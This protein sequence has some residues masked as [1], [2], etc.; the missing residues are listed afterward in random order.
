MFDI[1]ERIRNIELRSKIVNPEVAIRVFRKGMKVGI[2]GDI[3]PISEALVKCVEKS[4]DVLDLTLWSGVVGIDADLEWGRA[5]IIAR[6]LGQQTLLKEFINQGKVS[7]SDIPLG[8][9]FYQS[10][11][12]NQLGDLDVAI[13]EAISITKEGNIIPG[14]TL[15]DMPNFAQLAKK[16]I[17]KLN[18]SYPL[19][20]EG[21]HDIYLPCNP[22]VRKPISINR[23]SDRIGKCYIEVDKS[24][25]EGIVISERLKEVE[26]TNIS[27]ETAQQNNKIAEKLISFIEEEMVYKRLPRDLPPIEIGLGRI[28]DSVLTQLDSHGFKNLEFY[29][30]IVWDKMLSLIDKGKVKGVSGTA[31]YLTKEIQRQFFD[32]IE[33]YKKHIVLRPLEIADSP[34]IIARLGVIAINEAIEIDIYG[35]ANCSHIEGRKIVNGIGGAGDFA[36]NASLSIILLPS[37]RE[38]GNISC[39]VPMVT[40]VDITEHAVDIIVSEQGIADLRGLPP[41][42]RAKQIITCCSHPDY[43]YILLDYLNR[44]TNQVGGHEPHLFNEALLFHQRLIEFGKMRIM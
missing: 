16:I 32:N 14:V 28:S 37:T 21:I 18:I 44:A 22:P 41:I 29:S 12:T 15:A 4:G 7:Y 3:Y 2:S 17:I 25:I 36:Q 1:N 35:H 24:K 19:N 42:E 30:A 43:R 27:T 20:I 38:K 39:I 13:I 40:H 11:R 9:K 10:L 34:E 33:K 8:S 26:A 31:L 5:G 6:R 23:V